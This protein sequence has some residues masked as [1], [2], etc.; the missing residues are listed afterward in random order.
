[1][2]LALGVDAVARELQDE[3]FTQRAIVAYGK[4][5]DT[6]AAVTGGEERA[7]VGTEDD[8]A[9][10]TC[11][12]AL[13]AEADD[14]GFLFI[15]DEGIGRAAFRVIFFANGIEMATVASYPN[16]RWVGKPR[17]T[18]QI[19]VVAGLLI[20]TV[21]ANTL[22]ASVAVTAQPKQDGVFFCLIASC[23]AQ[24]HKAECPKINAIHI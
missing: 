18:G 17:V 22:L 19:G 16:K 20:E 10:S 12:I 15:D 4:F 1:M 14:F 9:G 5:S 3:V 11:M 24:E 7:L 23:E 21:D 8:V 2:V 6:S 13:A